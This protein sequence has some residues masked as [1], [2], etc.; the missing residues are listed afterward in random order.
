MGSRRVP[1]EVRGRA[2]REVLDNYRLVEE[3]AAELGI[4][5]STVA[6]YASEERA[7]RRARQAALREVPPTVVGE[8]DAKLI[9]FQGETIAALR[10]QVDMMRERFSEIQRILTE[11]S[12]AIAE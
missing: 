9:A 1:A 12:Q 8:K 2:A 6:R 7:A 3:V 4:A 5:G 10:A 11:V